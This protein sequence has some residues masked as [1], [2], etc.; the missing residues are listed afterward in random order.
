MS[1]RVARLLPV[2]LVPRLRGGS[3]QG[4]KLA[5]RSLASWFS[6][7]TPL[8]FV[9][10]L[11]IFGFFR[12][13]PMYLVDRFHLSVGRVSEFIGWVVLPIVVANVLLVG[14]LSKG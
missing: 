6:Y 10:Y 5:D 7:Q 3:A 1:L 13:Y 2:Y 12:V 8:N 14:A 11:A 9:L 4:G